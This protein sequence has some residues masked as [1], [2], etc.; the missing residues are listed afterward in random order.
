MTPID[1]LNAIIDFMTDD[2]LEMSD[3]ELLA[4]L[5]EDGI[6]VEACAEEVRDV[7][8]K[9]KQQARRDLPKHLQDPEQVLENGRRLLREGLFSRDEDEKS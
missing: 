9:A 8:E 2:Y 5:E 3:E 4:E 7:F 6:D 1:R